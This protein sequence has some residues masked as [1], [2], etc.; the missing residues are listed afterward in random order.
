MPP[1]GELRR[2]GQAGARSGRARGFEAGLGVRRAGPPVHGGAL[3]DYHPTTG[4]RGRL[5]EPDRRG[6]GHHLLQPLASVGPTR[7]S[8]SCG[9]AWTP[10]PPTRRSA[11]SCAP[12]TEGSSEL[13]PVLN[14]PTVRSGWSQG[15]GTT[16][17]VKWATGKSGAKKKCKSKKKRC[18]KA[19]AKTAA[20]KRCKAKTKRCKKA[21]G[22]LYVFA[23]S[24]G[25]SVKGR[26]SLPCVGDAKAAV[27][28][29][30]RTIPVHD[31]LLQRPLRGRK[32]D[33]H[34]P[35]RRPIDVRRTRRLR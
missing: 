34:L 6:A 33:P 15:P 11:R 24:A 3:A 5:A 27:L 12:R 30:N 18:K 14:S 8:T 9:M 23:G 2:H 31:G 4:T 13:A 25:S 17:M 35:H 7:P 21:K 28:G 29:E 10:A 19:K 22:H 1:G 26:F 32:R 20:K 16:A